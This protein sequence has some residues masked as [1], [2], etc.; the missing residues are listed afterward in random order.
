MRNKF[1]LT[2]KE[3]IFFRAPIVQDLAIEFGV[4]DLS[5]INAMYELYCKISDVDP[6]WNEGDEN[7]QNGYKA[8]YNDAIEECESMVD[9][10]CWEIGR[11]K[12][13]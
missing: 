13:R 1:S 11:L 6:F 5:A 4:D 12:K 10:T 9:S 3:F 7:Y 8:G 2:S